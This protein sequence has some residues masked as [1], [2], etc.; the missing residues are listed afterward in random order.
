MAAPARRV[1]VNDSLLLL[2]LALIDPN[3]VERIAGWATPRRIDPGIFEAYRRRFPQIDSIPA[4]GAVVPAGASVESILS[5]KPDLFV[6]GIWQVGWT[7]IV[8]RLEA[9]GVPVIFL[10]GPENAARNP[11]EA[12]AFSSELLGMA[13][14]RQEQAASFAAFVRAHYRSVVERLKGVEAR[15]NV[16]IDAFAGAECCSTPGRDNRLTQY[17]ELAGGKTIGAEI[18]AGYDGRLSPEYVLGKNPDVYIGTGGVRLP[19]QGGLALGGGLSAEAARASLVTVVS[20]GVRRELTA[21]RSRR[22]FGV[23]HQ[24]S[25]SALSILVFEC[26]AKWIHPDRFSDLDPARTLAEINRR[27]LPVPLEGTFWIG[28]GDGEER[29]N[30]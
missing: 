11:A 12:T 28:L 10:D 24:L 16:L 27:F 14:G 15:P 3:P 1:V 26:F 25:I 22:A 4:V 20:Q 21:V 17:L 18:I 6:V 23:S 9:A 19:V 29:F 2:S 7:E 13:I 8:N 30:P 5:G